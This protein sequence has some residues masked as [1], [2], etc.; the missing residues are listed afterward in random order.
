MSEITYIADKIE[1]VN[2][3][4]VIPMGQVEF[5]K[6]E[7]ISSGEVNVTYVFTDG[8]SVVVKYTKEKDKII[9]KE[10]GLHPYKRFVEY[11]RRGR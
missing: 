8:S 11:K 4:V 10:K 6:Q 7:R 3:E 9:K 1:E 5:E 2:G